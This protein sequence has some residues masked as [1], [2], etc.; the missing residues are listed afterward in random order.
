MNSRI[1]F[2]L[3]YFFGFACA[4]PITLTNKNGKSIE[5]T[6]ISATEAVVTASRKTDGKEFTIPLNTLDEESVGI[7][8]NWVK[9]QSN[10]PTER[11]THKFE[12]YTSNSE[13]PWSLEL[14][15]KLPKYDYG[16]GDQRYEVTY[17][18]DTG[19]FN[20]G[21]IHIRPWVSK[22]RD[23][24]EEISVHLDE[25][26]EKRKM[27]STPNELEKNKDILKKQIV[28][29]SGF[30]GYYI[31]HIVGG[32]LREYYLT[33]GKSYVGIRMVNA[34]IGG[35]INLGNIESIIATMK[36]NS[37]KSGE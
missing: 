14:E 33:D 30:S 12:N 13:P 8:I 23:S 22:S 7:I 16:I 25:I 5:A 20:K 17:S 31:D 32:N 1:I 11:K 3:L 19:Q 26:L 24:I 6:I 10:L 2:S 29:T 18:F 4:S 37:F 27:G 15:F 35:I 36:V 9:A 21:V 34:R 28:T